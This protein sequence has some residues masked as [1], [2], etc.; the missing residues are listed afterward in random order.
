MADMDVVQG[1]T[2]AL[3]FPFG[4]V[5]GFRL[6]EHQRL[7]TVRMDGDAFDA[8]GGLRALDHGR[9]AERLEGLGRLVR[10]RLLLPLELGDVVEQPHS[11]HGHRVAA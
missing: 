11:A 7:K 6:A 1:L 10:E 8:V 9:V 3:D 2:V 5:V 4:T